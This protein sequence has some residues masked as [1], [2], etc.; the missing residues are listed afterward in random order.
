MGCSSLFLNFLRLAEQSLMLLPYRPC[1]WI[2]SFLSKQDVGRGSLLGLETSRLLSSLQ[3]VR[4]LLPPSSH[5][6]PH[7]PSSRADPWLAGFLS[8]PT[9]ENYYPPTSFHGRISRFPHPDHH[10]PPLPLLHAATQEMEAYLNAS[11]GVGGKNVVV[12]HC[13]VS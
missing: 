4:S 1:L 12:I 13:K 5:T 9:S 2:R 6:V 8:C 7:F 3:L 10:P 11:P